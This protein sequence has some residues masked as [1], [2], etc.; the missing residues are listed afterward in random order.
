MAHITE[1]R[2]YF[3]VTKSL[4]MVHTS[5]P[6]KSIFG[7]SGALSIRPLKHPQTVFFYQHYLSLYQHLCGQK[8]HAL[9]ASTQQASYCLYCQL[10]HAKNNLK[11]NLK[12]TGKKQ[13]VSNYA[14]FNLN[15]HI[16]FLSNQ[17]IFQL[18]KQILI[19]VLDKK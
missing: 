9:Q 11:L 2:F 1:T 15:N 5:A 3:N 7:L 18:S 4:S 13:P 16:F 12:L 14:I 6:S 10:A 8:K 19:A 17:Q